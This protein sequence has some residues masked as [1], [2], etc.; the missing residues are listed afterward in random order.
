MDNLENQY[1]DPKHAVGFTGA[2]NLIRE[3]KKKIHPDVVKEWLTRHDTY[4]LHKAIRRKFPRLY[5]N[6]LSRD[7]V[8][9][10][11]LL[12]LTDIKDYNDGV[13]YLLVVIDCLSKYA[14]VR[15]LHNKTAEEVLG[16]FKSI[17]KDSGNRVPCMIQTDRG[18]EFTNQALSKYFKDNNIQFR[19]I[20][21][22]QVKASIVERLNRTLRDRLYRYFTFKNTK[23]YI[24]VLQD[25]VNSYNHASHSTIKM[26]PAAVTM[27]NAHIARQNLLKRAIVSQ[28]RGTRKAKYK[29]GQYVRISRE[30]NVFEKGAE[31]SWSEEIFEIKRVLHRQN[32][33]VYELK[34]LQ[35]E[36]IEGIFYSQELSP[37]HRD[38]AIGGEYQIEKILESRGKGK[39]K[40]H[41]V[42]WKGWNDNFNSWVKA[43]DV[44]NL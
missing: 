17:F 23:R 18:K 4:T 25:L 29:V 27:H 30:K 9:E 13:C 22:P 38:R 41:L 31:R 11:D 24:D 10:A 1:F 44:R 26:A 32:L 40:E 2:R 21:D 12:Q 28:G 43:A 33:H 8:W 16:A 15:P 19:T 5:Y 42:K 34:D 35:G 6:P 20:T 3:N 14:W 39:N 37:V 36:D 7:S